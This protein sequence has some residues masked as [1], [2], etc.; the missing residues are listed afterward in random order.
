MNYFVSKPD[1]LCH[2]DGM[3]EKSQILNEKIKPLVE[4]VRAAGFSFDYHFNT[5]NLHYTVYMWGD[6]RHPGMPHWRGTLSV[7]AHCDT[8]EIRKIVIKAEHLRTVTMR[9]LDKAIPA[10]VARFKESLVLAKRSAEQYQ[11]EQTAQQVFE[12]QREKDFEG[13]TVPKFL[14]YCFSERLAC[15][16]EWRLMNLR[17]DDKRTVGRYNIDGS[18]LQEVL[19]SLSADQVKTLCTFLTETLPNIK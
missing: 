18:G 7:E 3:N 9:V 12:A 6:L 2:N 1:C 19:R 4:A 14:E 8:V 11:K 17:S 15:Q 10:A 13:W 16:P 5:N